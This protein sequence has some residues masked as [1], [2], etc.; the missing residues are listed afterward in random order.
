[1]T[2]I[3][4]TS[5]RPKPRQPRRPR[6]PPTKAMIT[7]RTSE[8]HI[9][10]KNP[11]TS[12]PVIGAAHKAARKSAAAISAASSAAPSDRMAQ[13]EVAAEGR[14]ASTVGSLSA[15]ASTGMSGSSIRADPTPRFGA[16]SSAA[17]QG[18]VL[19]LLQRA[20]IQAVEFD[21]PVSLVTKRRRA[22]RETAADAA[23]ATRTKRTERSAVQATA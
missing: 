21:C 17:S 5:Q 2:S 6:R 9:P 15:T 16:A 7:G 22:L 1:M 23:G 10:P 14:G 18:S 3:S 13:E 19:R 11:A 8:P 12:P 20:R 4:Q